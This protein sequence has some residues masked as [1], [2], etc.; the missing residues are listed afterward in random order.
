MEEDGVGAAN[1][2][3]D[4]ES[5]ARIYVSQL[6]QLDRELRAEPQPHGLKF[7]GVS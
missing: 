5:E 2:P 3:T 6:R 4:G 1:Y 7:M